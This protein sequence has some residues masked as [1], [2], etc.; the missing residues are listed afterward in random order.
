MVYPSA[1]GAASP[2]T[3]QSLQYDEFCD[4]AGNANWDSAF[5]QWMVS[6][7]LPERQ[8]KLSLMASRFSG[9]CQFLFGRDRGGILP[10]EILWL[11]W[12]LFTALCRRVQGVYEEGGGPHLNLQPAHII[13]LFPGPVEDFLPVRWLFTLELADVET[14]SLYPLANAPRRLSINR[15]TIFSKPS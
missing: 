11:K 15:P 3:F 10:L 1:P 9:P 2:A 8:E 5:Q 6:G 4:L 12:N 14:A 7:L 13:V